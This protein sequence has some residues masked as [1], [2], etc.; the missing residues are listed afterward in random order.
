M[1]PA[2]LIY[3]RHIRN[4][5]A[6]D[7]TAATDTPTTKNIPHPPSQ[8]ALKLRRITGDYWKPVYFLLES[9]GF[10]CVLYHAAQVLSLIHI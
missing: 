1:R 2:P 10:D 3:Y 6:A 7:N 4:I 9:E 5:A 8:T